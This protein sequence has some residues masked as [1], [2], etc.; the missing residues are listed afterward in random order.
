[1]RLRHSFPSLC[2][3]S[4]ALFS[5]PNRKRQHDFPTPES[6]ISNS[7]DLWGLNALQPSNQLL[8]AVHSSFRALS[9]PP[10][11]GPAS[12]RV[13][14]IKCSTQL[15]QCV[16]PK[17]LITLYLS[18]QEQLN[19][20]QPSFAKTGTS[21]TVPSLESGAVGRR[22]VGDSSIAMACPPLSSPPPMELFLRH[23]FLGICVAIQWLMYN[24]I[25]IFIAENPRK[26]AENVNA[27]PKSND[28]CCSM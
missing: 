21:F 3:C 12:T 23:Y 18:R 17:N 13:V 27:K 15:S 1:M 9:L 22:Y 5:S 4:S 24:I 28:T 8:H 19:K 10:K 14:P 25:T 20:Y 16:T 11:S 2:N 6:P 26:A 7:F